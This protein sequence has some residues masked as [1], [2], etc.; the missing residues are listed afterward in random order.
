MSWNCQEHDVRSGGWLDVLDLR[1]LLG[2][3][4]AFDLLGLFGLRLRLAVLN[5]RT[6]GCTKGVVLL[7]G[8]CNNE[9]C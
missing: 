3:L 7:V 6:Q 5:G 8:H 2:L 4:C 1:G 9:R